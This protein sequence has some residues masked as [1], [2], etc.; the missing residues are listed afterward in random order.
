MNPEQVDR[1]S[2]EKVDS[3]LNISA[4]GS[5]GLVASMSL[6]SNK[7]AYQCKDGWITIKSNWVRG[8][9]TSAVELSTITRSFA[10][11]QGHLLEKRKTEG[12]LLVLVLPITYSTTS[13]YR[14]SAVEEGPGNSLPGPRP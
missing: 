3:G 11:S 5:G 4:L 14:Y 9:G 12:V 1:I 6:S 10:I 7:E 2:I 8:G 13:W